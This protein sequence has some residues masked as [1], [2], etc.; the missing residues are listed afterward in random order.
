MLVGSV[1]EYLLRVGNALLQ[2]DM[3]HIGGIDILHVLCT[4]VMS[5]FRRF[6]FLCMLVKG[7]TKE[8]LNTLHAFIHVRDVQLQP[9]S[10]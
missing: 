9:H 1:T 2:Y 4:L 6:Q 5:I 3:V 8:L 7:V 10:P